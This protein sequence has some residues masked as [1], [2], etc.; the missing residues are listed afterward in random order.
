[1]AQEPVAIRSGVAIMDP[2]NS[3]AGIPNTLEV[4]SDGSIN[5]SGSIS[6]NS[7]ATAT[8]AAP[9][10][11]EG[12]D[13]PLSQDLSGNLRTIAKAATSSTLTTS[14]VTVPATATGI[15]I[16]GANSSRKGAIIVNPGS[17]PVFFAQTNTVTVSNSQAIPPNYGSLNIDSPDYTGAIF[18]IVTTGTQVV[19]VSELT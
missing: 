11:S 3:T 19:Y 13:E 10:Y 5:I 1:M 4:N 6:A 7:S 2:N 18:G 15:Q 9:T 17:V 8:A 14:Q 12:V 16:L